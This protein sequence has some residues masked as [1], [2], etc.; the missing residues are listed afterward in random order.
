MLVQLNDVSGKTHKVY[1]MGDHYY[2]LDGATRP[3]LGTETTAQGIGLTG[4][5]GER[6]VFPYVQVRGFENLFALLAHYEVEA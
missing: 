2:K 1:L 5:D 3:A 4:K 6:V